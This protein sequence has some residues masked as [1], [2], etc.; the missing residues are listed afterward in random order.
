[1]FQF[2]FLVNW[3]L[4]AEHLCMRPIYRLLLAWLDS[5]LTHQ[6]IHKSKIEKHNVSLDIFV[7][8]TSIVR[9]HLPGLEKKHFSYIRT[10][11]IFCLRFWYLCCSKS[12]NIWGSEPYHRDKKKSAL[13]NY[14]ENDN[15]YGKN[16]SKG[17]PWL[18]RK[19]DSFHTV[20]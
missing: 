15:T 8:D 20:N 14:W 4:L 5:F 16:P 9:N 17:R 7:S 6:L 11:L 12:K 1:M 10:I 18:L 3:S 2:I 13:I 19:C